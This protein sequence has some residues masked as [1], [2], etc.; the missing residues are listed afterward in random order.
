ML[1]VPHHMSFASLED[2]LCLSLRIFSDHGGRVAQSLPG[3]ARSVSSCLRSNLQSLR[4]GSWCINTPSHP[5][6]GHLEACSSRI[7]GSPQ[8]AP[9]GHNR[10]L[11]I[12]IC[13]T[14]SPP[15]PSPLPTLSLW[16]WINYWHQNPCLR[17]CFCGKSKVKEPQS[18]CI[19]QG[20]WAIW[21]TGHHL[22]PPKPRWY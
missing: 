1:S 15:S 12:N 3:Q 10:N 16:S 17:V 20:S 21:N 22:Y 19:W 2:F 9:I 4:G 7:S 6:V 5:S 18:L 11:L 13:F 14:G 8:Q